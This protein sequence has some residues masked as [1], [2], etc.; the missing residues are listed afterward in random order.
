MICFLKDFIV[1][2]LCISFILHIWF[3]LIEFVINYFPDVAKPDLIDAVNDCCCNAR[4][5]KKVN[6]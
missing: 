3:S 4:G 5:K 6:I 1:T 2:S